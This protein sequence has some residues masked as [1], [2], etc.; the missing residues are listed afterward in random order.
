MTATAR[1]QRTAAQRMQEG[2]QKIAD[3]GYYPIKAS[4]DLR[5]IK[6]TILQVQIATLKLAAKELV[7]LAKEIGDDKYSQESDRRYENL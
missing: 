4:R 7:R 2:M 3:D 1:P 5:A 6:N